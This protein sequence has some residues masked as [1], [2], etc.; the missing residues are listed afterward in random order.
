M[1]NAG[2]LCT[3]NRCK[4]GLICESDFHALHSESKNFTCSVPWTSELTDLAKNF[5]DGYTQTFLGQ[6]E[7]NITY[8]IHALGSPLLTGTTVEGVIPSTEEDTKAGITGHLN[9]GFA[10]DCI[11]AFPFIA[12]ESIRSVLNN[13]AAKMETGQSESM[14]NSLRE[15]LKIDLYE[16]AQLKMTEYVEKSWVMYKKD[17]VEA[18]ET[19]ME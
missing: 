15:Q 9:M 16:R 19:E 10:D 4:A 11:A 2:E 17:T 1:Q 13:F 18:F 3:I 7:S 5:T 8:N 12:K 6:L 14:I